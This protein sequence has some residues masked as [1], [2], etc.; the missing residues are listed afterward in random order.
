MKLKIILSSVFILLSISNSVLAQNKLEEFFGNLNESNENIF[1]DKSFRQTININD[2]WYYLEDNMDAPENL[3]QS[4]KQWE[5]INLPHTWN[6]FDAT[7]AEPGY[8]RSVSWYE[9]N[10]FVPALNKGTILKLYFEGV[11]ITSDVYVNG[12]RAGGHIGGYLGFE[13]DITPFIKENSTN[14]IL[15]RA[16]N[17]YNPEVPPSQKSDFVIFGGISRDVWLKVLPSS[18]INRIHISTPDVSETSASTHVKVWIENN[19]DFKNLSIKAA[20]KDKDNNEVLKFTKALSLEKI[21]EFDFTELNAPNLWSTDNPYLYTVEIS[22]KNDDKLIDTY[23]DRFGYRWYEFKNNGPFYL[24]GKRLLL[25]GTHRHEEYAGLGNA[26]P[27]S[28]HRKDIE[29]IK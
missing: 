26:L 9:K 1:E 24:N 15:V 8:R 7:D 17:S 22:L 3:L 16:D 27:N 13:I 6:N 19:A 5:K 25:R 20:V 23:S 4:N 14:I 11:N 18:Y 2:N 21:I 28:L 12:Q 10:L 29:M